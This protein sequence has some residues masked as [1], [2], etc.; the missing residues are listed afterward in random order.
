MHYKLGT[1]EAL[2]HTMSFAPEGCHEHIGMA[3]MSNLVF[4]AWE[5]LLGRTRLPSSL[6]PLLCDKAFLQRVVDTMKPWEGPLQS[7]CFPF[8]SI[9]DAR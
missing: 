5:T 1:I 8:R 6:L 3:L 7:V 9:L 4:Q 2:S